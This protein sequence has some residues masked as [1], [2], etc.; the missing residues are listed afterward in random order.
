M[1]VYLK[2][3]KTVHFS[4]F[5]ALFYLIN[6]GIVHHFD[7]VNHLDTVETAHS[8]HVFAFTSFLVPRI[9]KVGRRPGNEATHPLDSVWTAHDLT[10]QTLL[11][12]LDEVSQLLHEISHLPFEA[13]QS[14]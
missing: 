8:K 4:A 11:R 12:G 6:I 2:K 3:T 10:G 14:K 7:T 5:P 9:A 13:D 1:C